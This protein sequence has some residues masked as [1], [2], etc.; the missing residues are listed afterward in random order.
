MR[1]KLTNF[2]IQST[3]IYQEMIFNKRYFTLTSALFITEVLIGAFM[4]DRLIRPFGGDL[5]IVILI[6]CFVKS[7]VNTPWFKTA[8]ATL[9]FAYAVEFSQYLNLL[10]LLG[11]QNSKLAAI[12]LGH[13]FSWGDMLCYT[14]GTLIVMIIETNNRS[15]IPQPSA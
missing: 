5:L 2:E 13:S 9:L 15:S 11:W 14:I 12:L 6:Y 10:G 1:K 7:F 8:L 4:H 3:F